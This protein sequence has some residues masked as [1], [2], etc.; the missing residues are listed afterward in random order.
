MSL[1]D[2]HWF[3]L[4]KTHL[5]SMLEFGRGKDSPLFGGVID[6][7]RRKVQTALTP[8]PPGIRIS[9]FN[10]CGNN[11]MHDVPLLE[12]MSLL[13]K[14]TGDAKYEQALGEM[15]TFYGQRCP[16]P[17][18]G[19]FPWGEHAQWSFADQ[20]IVPCSFTNGLA[21][22]RRDG[23]IIH[24]HLRFAPGWFW[25]RMWNEN[26]SAVVNFAKGLN[27]HIVDNK[28]FEHNRHAVI[29]GAWWRD[30]NNPTFDKGADFARHSGFYIFD[31]L[32]AYKHSGDESLFEWARKKLA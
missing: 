5:D 23:S 12:V 8:P 15:F 30:P 25:Q 6:I 13:G 11:L 3:K 31:C 29:C 1:I 19:L 14:L 27:G 26:P 21:N 16:L 10:W 20:G 17:E 32:F 7:G 24:D 28:T 2:N 4:A 18:T 22:F 9:D